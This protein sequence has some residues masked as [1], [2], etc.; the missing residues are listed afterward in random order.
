MARR[1]RE[2]EEAEDAAAGDAAK[3]GDA[4]KEG[5]AAKD[6]KKEYVCNINDRSLDSSPKKWDLPL[7][8]ATKSSGSTVRSSMTFPT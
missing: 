7:P 1:R 5:D 3:D 4:A 6:E 8:V 2:G